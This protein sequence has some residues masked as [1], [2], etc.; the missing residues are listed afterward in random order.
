MLELGRLKVPH[1]YISQTTK[2]RLPW[3]N[4]VAPLVAANVG[5]AV[6]PLSCNATTQI[7]AYTQKVRSASA[8]RERQ[9]DVLDLLRRGRSARSTPKKALE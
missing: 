7:V 4:Q 9:K 6:A 5:V 8:R 1:A 2:Q 3:V